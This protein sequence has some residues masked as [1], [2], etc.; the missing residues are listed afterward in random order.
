MA[1]ITLEKVWKKYG[2]VEAVKGIDLTFR[3]GQFHAILGPSGCGKTSTLRMIAGLEEITAGKISFGERV[4]NELTPSQRDLAMAFEDYALYPALSVFENIAFPLRAPHRAM[5]YD[6]DQIQTKVQEMAAMLDLTPILHHPVKR[7]SGGQQ[8]RVSLARALIRP[9]SV[10][11]LDEP[12]SRPWLK[13]QITSPCT[14][15]PAI[16]QSLLM[17]SKSKCYGL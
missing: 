5:H 16:S 4:I 7:L 6:A 3:D 17:R 2:N 15:A 14:T 10:Y 9:A 8:Q 1:T 11:L 12:L 13:G